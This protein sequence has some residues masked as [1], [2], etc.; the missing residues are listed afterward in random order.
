MAFLIIGAGTFGTRAAH[1]LHGEHPDARIIL[2]DSD[3]GALQQWK[4]RIDTELADGIDYLLRRLDKDGGTA[5][6]DWIVPAVPVHLAYEWIRFTLARHFNVLA[7]PVPDAADVCLPNPVRGKRGELYTS[8]ATF[9]CPENCPAPPDICTTTGNFRGVD[10][11]KLLEQLT[12]PDVRS[13]VVRSQ[14]LAPGVGG[15]PAKALFDARAEIGL[16]KGRVLV[17]TACRCHG[18]VHALQIT[19]K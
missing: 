16:T 15:Y 8:Y 19:K 12:L 6:A 10:L 2:V 18:V 4:G 9:R 3:S 17:S 1:C 7:V 5:I 11:Y 13:V 14:Q